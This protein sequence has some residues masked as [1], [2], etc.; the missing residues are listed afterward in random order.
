MEKKTPHAALV[1]VESPAK[2][3]T[4]EKILGKRYRV[5]ASMGHIIDL[6]KSKMGIDVAKGFAPQYI[7][8][9]AKRKV[10]TGLKDAVKRSSE[11]YL[12]CDPDREGEAISWHLGNELGKGL[13]KVY[14]VRFN[15]ITKSALEEAFRHPGEIDMNLVGAQQ[16]RRV[17]DR[18]VGYSLSPLLWAKVAK[19]LSAGRV[20]SVALR[21]VTDRER[22]I[23]AFVPQEYWTLDARLEKTVPPK[24]AFGATLEKKNGAKIEIVTAAEA[25]AVA[26]DVRK[27]TFEVAEVR[28]TSK[29]RSPPA[30][31][32]TS[33]L[34]QEAYN[35]LGFPPTRAMRIAQTLYEGVDLGEG[36]TV[37]LITYM[38]TDSV[39]VSSSALQEVRKYIPGRFGADF[40]PP[41][42]HVYKSKKSA[43]EAHE[44][45]RPTSVFREPG[46]IKAF[47]SKEQHEL[48]EL[49]WAKFVASQMKPAV[50][51]Q[52]S[53][54]I[55]A[56]PYLFKATGSTVV[57]AGFLA[58]WD[59]SEKSDKES[60]PPLAKGDRLN[61]LKL[62]ENQ[63]FTKPPPRFTDAS[64]VKLLEEEGIGRPSTYA[65]IIQTLALRHYVE[66]QGGSLV[67]TELGFLVVD[68]LVRHFPKLMET[69]FT[70][71]LE[72]D[73]DHIE[74]GKR[75]WV[76]VLK[77]FYGE[78]SR[79][80][81]KARGD[82]K[83]VKKLE[84][85]TDEICEKC[86]RPMVVKW[87]RRGKFL[88]CSG[89]PECRF[90]KSIPTSVRC[91]GCGKGMLVARRARSGQGRSFY[92]CSRYPECTHIANRLPAPTGSSEP[93]AETEQRA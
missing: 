38:R 53:V 78:F 85:K 22:K 14:R 39:N 2:C 61:L 88:S 5:M 17:L 41:V 32:T 70:A 40:L 50:L 36:E 82:M 77:E 72:A 63:H 65:P 12:A 15:E 18:L 19:G 46:K 47:L 92:G 34:Q 62:G 91:P 31:F 24:E 89:F 52:S 33:K 20:Q 81:E 56:G 68:L 59:D 8:M 51:S 16:A 35:R 58:A 69:K 86:S 74:E 37:G 80:L 64:L 28:E 79:L 9:T 90:S 76:D 4:I 6:P 13:K 44:A 57:F 1:I 55:A 42:P 7:V 30:P 60:L 43:Q 66:R 21:I 83:E 93:A 26:A 23:K 73:L 49:I 54:D 67:P 10:L 45:I 87:G 29:K 27:Q 11:L 3:H 71:H 75:A 25:Q 84:I 48:Y